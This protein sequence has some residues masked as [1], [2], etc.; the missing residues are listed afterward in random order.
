MLERFE[1]YIIVFYCLNIFFLF[2]WNDLDGK[3]QVS[4]F[5]LQ[6]IDEIDPRGQ[7]YKTFYGRNLQIFVIS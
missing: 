4:K 1:S 3:K 6:F 5:T 7:G 2:P